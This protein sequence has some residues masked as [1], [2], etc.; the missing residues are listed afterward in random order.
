[1]S[2]N[3]PTK[4]PMIMVIDDN[5]DFLSGVELTLE[6]EGFQVSTAINGQDALDK[7]QQT[8]RGEAG[9]DVDMGRLPDLILADIM[10]P[11][12]NGYEFYEQVRSNPYLN[13]IP[14]VF[15][16]AK[17]DDAD[18]RQGKALGVD[19]YLR[20]PCSTE[21]LLASVN[22]K[23]RRI[24]RQRELTRQFIGDDVEEGSSSNLAIILIVF[25]GLVGIGVCLGVLVAYFF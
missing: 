11:T 3:Q 20:K 23:L 5:P 18:V 4:N 7:L 24:E 8:F 17:T 21:D 10:M 19:D 16:T 9:D 1:M 15:L 14:F 6:M 12:M 22:G 25:G 2:E 13:H